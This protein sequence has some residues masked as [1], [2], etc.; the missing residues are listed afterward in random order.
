MRT[1]YRATA[2]A[3]AGALVLQSGGCPDEQAPAP[4]SVGHNPNQAGVPD[5]AP[6]ASPSANNVTLHFAVTTEIPVAVTWNAGHGNKF[7]DLLRAPGEGWNAG[8]PKGAAVYLG[9]ISAHRNERGHITVKIT[10]ATTGKLICVDSNWTNT[11][12]GADC[13]GAAK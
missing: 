8:A 7:I 2:L 9:A 3:L 6:H 12:A 10:N 11:N 4:S 13:Q 1:R 5:P